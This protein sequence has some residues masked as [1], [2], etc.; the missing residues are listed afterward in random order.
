MSRKTKECPGC[1]MEID[2]D[3]T[4]CPICQYEFSEQKSNIVWI[5][6]ALLAI[7]LI[8]PVYLLIKKLV[9]SLF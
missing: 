9:T 4:V 8:Y 1:A 2:A 5:G 6:M 3:E 7:S